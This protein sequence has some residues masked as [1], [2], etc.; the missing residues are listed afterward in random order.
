[1][2]CMSYVCLYEHAVIPTGLAHQLSFH[3]SPSF[4]LWTNQINVC[5]MDGCKTCLLVPLTDYNVHNFVDLI[6]SFDIL[7]FVDVLML[8]C[9]CVC[10]SVGSPVNNPSR[11][12]FR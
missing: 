4:L 6:T 3:L 2:V 8:L 5:L 10:V 11:R 7:D 1:M 12:G 9:D